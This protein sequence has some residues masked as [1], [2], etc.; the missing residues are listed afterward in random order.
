MQTVRLFLSERKWDEVEL[1]NEKEIVFLNS[2]LLAQIFQRAKEAK[3]EKLRQYEQLAEDGVPSAQCVL[4][5]YYATGTHGYPRD[6]DKGMELFEEAWQQDDPNAGCALG[7]CYRTKAAETTDPAERERLYEM[8]HRCFA[9]DGELGR[10]MALFYLGLTYENGSGVE[11]DPERAV[12]CYEAA[13]DQGNLPALTALGV[14]HFSG[15]GMDRDIPGGLARLEQAAEKGEPRAQ[16]ILGN[17]YLEGEQV[18]K[19]AQRAVK[20]YEAAA[21]RRYPRGIASLGMVYANGIGRKQDLPKA[22][23]LMEKAA[24][25]GSKEAEQCLPVIR[26]LAEMMKQYPDSQEK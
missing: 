5:L 25:L 6:L 16:C 11:R 15:I 20:L 4:G 18:P 13:S 22:I 1:G 26:N 10:P 14:C 2:S 17:L 24:S 19:D 23:E 3:A 9:Q 7:L 21:E 12:E 8:A